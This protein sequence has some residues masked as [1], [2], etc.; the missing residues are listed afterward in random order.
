[1]KKETV[2]RTPLFLALFP[3]STFL[4]LLLQFQYQRLVLLSPPTFLIYQVQNS[5]FGIQ[6]IVQFKLRI[7]CYRIQ[8]KI[9][10]FLLFFK[11]TRNPNSKSRNQNSTS[12]AIPNPS[13]S[14][15]NCFSSLLMC[16]L[17]HFKNILEEV[18]HQLTIFIHELK[19]TS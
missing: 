3:S 19:R 1:M 7:S 16:L 4:C 9:V 2:S 13:I 12:P 15:V 11:K 18:F 8:T 10:T 14:K 17:Y 5:R 6:S